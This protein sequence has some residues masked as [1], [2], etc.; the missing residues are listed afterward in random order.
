MGANTRDT[1]ARLSLH[2][3]FAGATFQA[4]DIWKGMQHPLLG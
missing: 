3:N 4:G 2:R 1:L